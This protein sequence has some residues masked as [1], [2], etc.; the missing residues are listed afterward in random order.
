[1]SQ[2]RQ[3]TENETSVVVQKTNICNYGEARYKLANALNT[4]GYDLTTDFKNAVGQLSST[5]SINDYAQF[6][7]DWGTV[8]NLKIA[9]RDV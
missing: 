4:P 9:C 1:M 3:K 7:D 8:S 6:L 5:Y 2:M